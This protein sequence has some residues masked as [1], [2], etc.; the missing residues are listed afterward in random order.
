[1][2]TREKESRN[3]VLLTAHPFIR[4]YG[5]TN[6]FP[7]NLK[8]QLAPFLQTALNSCKALHRESKYTTFLRKLP[9]EVVV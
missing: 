8:E 1:M 4:I 3:V 2:Y 6:I 7:E 9:S 5:K